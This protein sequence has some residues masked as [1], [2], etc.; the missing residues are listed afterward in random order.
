MSINRVMT[1]STGAWIRITVS[2][3][4]T[5]FVA[6]YAIVSAYAHVHVVNGVMIVHSHPFSDQHSH[7]AGQTLVLHFLTDFHS[8]EASG[9]TLVLHFLTDFHSLEASEP[10]ILD[11]PFQPVFLIDYT[12]HVPTCLLPEFDSGVGLRAPPYSS[13]LFV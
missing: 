11:T 7:T 1:K 8:L 3:F 9:Q 6:Y 10:L 2:L 13:F 4:L 5:V 12:E